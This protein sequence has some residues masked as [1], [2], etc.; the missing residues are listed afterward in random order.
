MQYK[1]STELWLGSRE[2]LQVC[3]V[4]SCR[5]DYIVGVVGKDNKILS[6]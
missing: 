3:R 4:R 5:C 6:G 1:Q 2:I